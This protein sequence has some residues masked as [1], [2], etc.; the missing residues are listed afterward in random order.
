MVVAVPAAAEV[1]DALLFPEVSP[2]AGKDGK[3]LLK[4]PYPRLRFPS[5]ARCP[6]DLRY[7]LGC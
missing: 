6:A 3:I 2:D 4:A 5:Q 7:P 1:I